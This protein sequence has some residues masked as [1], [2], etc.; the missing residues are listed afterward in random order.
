MFVWEVS[1]R[2]F[3]SGLAGTPGDHVFH[4]AGDAALA[5]LFLEYVMDIRLLVLIL[6][7]VAAFLAT[8]LACAQHS[9]L[10]CLPAIGRILAGKTLVQ[11]QVGGRCRTDVEVLMQPK[12]LSGARKIETAFLQSQRMRGS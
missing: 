9:R 11:N 2:R 6:D 4:F 12:S 1:L 10:V 7:L 5:Q 3:G 8:G